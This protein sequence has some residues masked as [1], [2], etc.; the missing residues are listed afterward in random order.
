VEVNSIDNDFAEII[1]SRRIKGRAIRS[2]N[3]HLSHESTGKVVEGIV[4]RMER[5]GRLVANNNGKGARLGGSREAKRGCTS[6]VG[7][8][9]HGKGKE[10]RR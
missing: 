5:K 2:R 3:I 10:R 8:Q 4:R 7:K 9:G 1:F 6:A